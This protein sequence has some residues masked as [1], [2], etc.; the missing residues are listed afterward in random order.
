MELYTNNFDT[1]IIESELYHTSVIPTRG[2]NPE[3]SC[4]TSS[5]V[6]L[7]R[8]LV[9]FDYGKVFAVVFDVDLC[10]LKLFNLPDGPSRY[11]LVRC[12]QRVQP[13]N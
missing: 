1:Y 8:P 9:K 11:T 4:S 10:A 6:H 2:K 5:M 13:S 7:L 3:V 12:I